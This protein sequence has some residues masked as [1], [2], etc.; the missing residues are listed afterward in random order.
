VKLPTGGR[1][2]KLQARERF[3]LLESDSNKRKV[4][5]SSPILEPTV[6]V[7]MKEDAF[8]WLSPHGAAARAASR[9]GAF[10]F[11]QQERFK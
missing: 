1:R 3:L 2:R 9:L 7:R 8:A 4:S 10:L 5:R 6:I 11:N